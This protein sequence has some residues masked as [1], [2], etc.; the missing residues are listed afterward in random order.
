[1][2]VQIERETLSGKRMIS[3]VAN[4][5]VSSLETI[6]EWIRMLQLAERWL[7]KAK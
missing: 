2:I 3:V 5:R 4:D 7:R 1:M 6:A